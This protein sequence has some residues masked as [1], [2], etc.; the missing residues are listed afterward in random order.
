MA[1]FTEFHRQQR[2]RL[3][4]EGKCRGGRGGGA[5]AG[6]G[7]RRARREVGGELM[8]GPH[9]SA[10]GRVGRRSWAVR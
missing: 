4:G 2:P 8:R 5:A 7:R 9:L 6:H 3:V 10:T 1:R